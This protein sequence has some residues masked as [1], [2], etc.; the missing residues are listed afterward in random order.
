M[1][2]FFD[3]DGEKDLLKVCRNYT[4]NEKSRNQ[5]TQQNKRK[6]KT[7]LHQPCINVKN[8]S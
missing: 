2:I 3:P 4:I 5:I 8:T 6:K 1:H 7:Q